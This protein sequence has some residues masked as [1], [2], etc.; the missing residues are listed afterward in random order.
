MAEGFNIIG[1]VAGNYLTLLAL[2]ATLPPGKLVFIGDVIDR[3]PSSKECIEFCKDHITLLGNH[4][5]MMR[6]FCERPKINEVMLWT[7]NGGKETLRQFEEGTDQFGHTIYGIPD[8]VVEWLQSLPITFQTDDLFVSH[9][10]F[11]GPLPTEEEAKLNQYYTVWNRWPPSKRREKFQIF[12]HNADM[13]LR[14]FSD[15][16]GEYAI[17]IDTSAESILT[18]IHWPSREIFQQPYIDRVPEKLPSVMTDI[19]TMRDEDA[20]GET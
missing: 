19:P 15:E 2:L 1:D 9:A 7:Q 12:G 3:G 8:E 16:L 13:P 18:G 11:S 4:E 6:N 17:C 5:L 10:P 14:R 20:L